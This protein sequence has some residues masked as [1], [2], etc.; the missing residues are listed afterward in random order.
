LAY[1]L[2]AHHQDEAPPMSE[3]DSIRAQAELVSVMAGTP[4]D[5]RDFTG[6]NLSKMDLRGID[7]E[8]AFLESADLSGANLSG[9]RLKDVVLS[10]ANLA[11]ANLSGADLTRANLG[12][13]KLV[14]ADLSSANLTE[15]ILDSCDLTGATL[16][17]ATMDKAQTLE[18]I[19]NGVDFTHA[20]AESLV[21]FKAKLRDTKFRG[22]RINL[23]IF[24]E[25]ELARIDATGAN[26]SQSVLLMSNADDAVFSGAQVENFR[27]VMSSMERADFTDAIMPGSNLRGAKLA[28]ASFAGVNLRRS[29]ISGADLTGAKM[30]RVI[31]VECLL[32]DA[33]LAGASLR[34]ANLMLAIMH[35]ANLRGADVSKA[36]LFCADLTGAEGDD[37][38]SFSGSNVKRA[39]VAGVYHG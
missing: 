12:R 8:G 17:R 30:E 5:R 7:L 34:G 3:E 11:G 36:N 2:S 21:F 15:A 37:K 29:D 33:I 10:R 6:A 25:C 22:A 4:R 35:R 28:G 1:R 20:K 16:S 19:A 18:I 38:T 13:A 9:A 23:C 31:L 26:F 14:K 24:H 32:L 39:L 27:V